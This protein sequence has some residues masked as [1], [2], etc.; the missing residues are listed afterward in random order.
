MYTVR[1]SYG[2]TPPYGARC[3]MEK[4]QDEEIKKENRETLEKRRKLKEK[5]DKEDNAGPE[6]LEENVVNDEETLYTNDL[7]REMTILVTMVY[8]GVEA[9]ATSGT[10]NPGAPT[11]TQS[12]A[13]ENMDVNTVNLFQQLL[14]QQ[15]ENQLVMKK[16]IKSMA[17][18]E[19]TSPRMNPPINY[20]HKLSVPE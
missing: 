1:Y 9:P 7:E 14:K 2:H 12:T 17:G 16:I 20:G 3:A 10:P 18:S 15:Q 6:T 11:N 4:K 19:G 13:A 8:M 5:K